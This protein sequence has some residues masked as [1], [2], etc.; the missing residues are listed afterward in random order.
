MELKQINDQVSVTGQITPDDVATIKAAGFTTIINNRPDGEVDPQPTS[1]EIAKAAAEVGI[2]YQT[3][4]MGREGVSP[5]M[6]TNTRSALDASSGPVL[7]F[8]R[9][10]TRST[11]LWAL[12]QAGQ[13]DAKSIIAEAAGA[14]YD[15]SHLAD[16]LG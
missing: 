9:T 12:S 1:A 14:G 3:I 5:E 13:M 16:H 2:D 11:T 10:G 15:I 7:C 8:C 4:P 6:V